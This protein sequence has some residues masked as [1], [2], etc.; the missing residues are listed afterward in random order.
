MFGGCCTNR[1]MES[2]LYRDLKA[3]LDGFDLFEKE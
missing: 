2:Q 1:W 3:G